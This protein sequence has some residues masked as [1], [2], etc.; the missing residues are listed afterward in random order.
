MKIKFEGWTALYIS[1]NIWE[2]LIITGEKFLH[3]KNV[4]SGI[5]INKYTI[6]FSTFWRAPTYCWFGYDF[7]VDYFFLVFCVF[8]YTW[9]KNIFIGLQGVHWLTSPPPKPSWEV[10]KMA[11]FSLSLNLFHFYP[12]VKENKNFFCKKKR[13]KMHKKS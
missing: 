7:L 8:F 4:L 12:K 6:F 3:Q 2:R 11:L 1:E 5:N 13:K 10:E 9:S